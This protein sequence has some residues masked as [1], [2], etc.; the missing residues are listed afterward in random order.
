MNNNDIK[1]KLN[2]YWITDLIDTEG[3]FY[4]RFAKSKNH[5]TG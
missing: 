4:V 3:C 5:K 2:P 1:Y